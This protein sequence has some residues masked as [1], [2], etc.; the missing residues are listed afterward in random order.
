M[1]NVLMLLVPICLFCGCS[2][3]S[4]QAE[5]LPDLGY[6]LDHEWD[7]R[8]E[9]ERTG[10]A[11]CSNHPGA[12]LESVA[13][14][15]I[16]RYYFQYYFQPAAHPRKLVL[17]VSGI[18]GIEGMAGSAVLRMVLRE[19]SPLVDTNSVS[20]A[21]IHNANP[22]G[23][24]HLSRETELTND[25]LALWLSATTGS[26]HPKTQLPVEAA[27]P[28]GEHSLQYY[29]LGWRLW[30]ASMFDNA[31]WQEKLFKPRISSSNEIIPGL[32]IDRIRKAAAGCDE[33]LVIDIHTGIGHWAGLSVS[34][35]ENASRLFEGF[36]EL[37]PGPQQAELSWG[38]FGDG[39]AAIVPSAQVIPATLFIGTMNGGY[40]SA[41]AATLFTMVRKNQGSLY[42]YTSEDERATIEKIY[43]ATFYPASIAWKSEVMAR[44]RKFFRQALK[45]FSEE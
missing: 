15:P 28:V 17:L 44:S 35:P 26:A 1:R 12:I 43:K 34:A 25:L 3:K 18:H 36:R 39:V 41:D 5:K 27:G 9:F 21:V 42:G 16:E 14:N 29:G 45:K 13:V 22:A 24:I 7:S 30:L 33:I 37:K 20:F 10:I 2:L 6:Y 32:F 11:M 31:R 4:Y 19:L 40:P 38:S 8:P 23:M